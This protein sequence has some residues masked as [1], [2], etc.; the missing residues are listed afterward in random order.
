MLKKIKWCFKIKEGLK[1]VEPN[2]DLSKL[3]LNESK[4]SLKRA[5]KCFQEGDLL[6]TTVVLYY[7]EYYA[8]YSFLL[9]I[10]IKSENHSCSIAIVEYIIGNVNTII[11]QRG[12]RIDAQYYMRT[13]KNKEVGIML[14]EAKVFVGFYDN[15]I[16]NLNQKEIE[17]FR[18]SIPPKSI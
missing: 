18:S 17:Q 10:G 3:F 9:K 1:I 15:L 4:L 12:K 13:G 14:K 7:A 11:K 16:S 8:I 6:W 5:E 2:D